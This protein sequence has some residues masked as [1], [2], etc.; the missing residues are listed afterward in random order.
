MMRKPAALTRIGLVQTILASGFV[1]WLIFFPGSATNFAWPIAPE[2]SAIFL[3]A[4]FIA[5]TYLG[6]SLFRE[7]HWHRL[8]WQ[9]WGNYAFLAVIL[10]ATFWHVGEMNWKSN[11]WIAHIWVLA[12]IIEPLT[13]PLFEPRGQAAKTP[14][15]EEERQGPI[16]VGL[17]RTLL[18][19]FVS[20][21]T[22]GLLLFINPE[23]MDT[24][25]PWALT[26]F[27][28]RVM[29]AFPILA[30]MWALHGYLA[31]DWAEIKPGVMG[32]ILFTTALFIIWL[33]GLPNYDRG[34]ENIVQF[35]AITG[36]FA[37]LL[38][39]YYV[40]QERARRAKVSLADGP[41]G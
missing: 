28:A 21:V 38:G 27:D 6:V 4:G 26:A 40:R 35:G 29:A 15:P 12:Y 7:S 5:R 31:E 8:R 33:Y 37:L 36:I 41:T 16:F 3:G 34:R 13:L 30:G 17:K 24:R 18:V 25:W 19:G 39:F 32:T 10:L 20:G 22:L 2:M 9:V 11:I 14:F 23:F 1:I